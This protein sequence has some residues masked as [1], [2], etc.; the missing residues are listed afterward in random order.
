VILYFIINLMILS[1][2]KILLNFIED[3]PITNQKYVCNALR[4]DDM[5]AFLPGLKYRSPIFDVPLS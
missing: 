5:Y 4:L 2:S 3:F 1:L